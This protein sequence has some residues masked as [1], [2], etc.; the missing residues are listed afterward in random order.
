MAIRSWR[1]E[2]CRKATW[3]ADRRGLWMRKACLL[4]FGAGVKG[5]YVVRKFRLGCSMGPTANVY[6]GERKQQLVFC[7]NCRDNTRVLDFKK[8][9]N[10]EI[11]QL[12]HLFPFSV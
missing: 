3:F 6:I 9:K 4:E 8:R 7:C 2:V 1:E 12:A 5:P 10:D 11:L